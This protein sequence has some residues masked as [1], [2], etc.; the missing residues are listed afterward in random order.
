[1]LITYLVVVMAYVFAAASG[2]ALIYAV[3]HLDEQEVRSEPPASAHT[4]KLAA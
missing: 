4:P 1:M 2:A 3:D